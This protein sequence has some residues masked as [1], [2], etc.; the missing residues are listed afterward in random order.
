VKLLQYFCY[1]PLQHSV[2]ILTV[3][4]IYVNIEKMYGF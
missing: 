4:I 2:K 1:L 3:E